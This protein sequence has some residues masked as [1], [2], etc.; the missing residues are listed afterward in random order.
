MIAKLDSFF[1]AVPRPGSNPVEIGAFT[2]FVSESPFGYYARP[3]LAHPESI[4]A[5]DL[6]ALEEAFAE[7]NVDLSIEWVEEAHPEL[8]ELAMVHGLEVR[9]HALMVILN[10]AVVLPNV[11]GVRVRLVG[12]EDA[13]L[14][15]GLAVANLSFGVGGTDA[16]SVGLMERDIAVAGMDDAF[17]EYFRDRARRGLTFTAVAESSEGVLAVASYQSANKAAEIVGVATLPMAR[18]RGLGAAVTALLTTHAFESGVE[19]VLLSAQNDDVA[20][21]YE[22]IGF[23]R[24]GFTGAAERAKK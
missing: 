23:H 7:R 13:V 12:A 2:L 20:R 17:V 16:G 3:S 9:S 11:E 21:V 5:S 4:E 10:D 6:V 14:V 24:I 19:I 8:A 18:K 15:D 22:R 1:D